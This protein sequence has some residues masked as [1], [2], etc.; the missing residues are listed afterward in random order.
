LQQVLRTVTLTPCTDK[1]STETLKPEGKRTSPLF[2]PITHII[3]FFFSLGCT[4]FFF[5]VSHQR[6]EPT[7]RA[8][9]H[10]MPAHDGLSC[11]QEEIG[12]CNHH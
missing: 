5:L 4:Q 8:S 12:V 10:L 3:L 1:K 6:G 11:M 9:V 7:N 2:C